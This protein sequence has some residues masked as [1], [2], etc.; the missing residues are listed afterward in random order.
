M[1]HDDGLIYNQLT[2][3][4]LTWALVHPSHSYINMSI[5][6]AEIFILKIQVHDQTETRAVVKCGL[7]YH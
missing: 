2:P 1:A 6:D 3:E 4:G 5:M 7:V